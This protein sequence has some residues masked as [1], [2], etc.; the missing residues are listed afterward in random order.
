MKKGPERK[1]A[2]GSD[3]QLVTVGLPRDVHRMLRL[4][5]VDR[6]VTM[7]ELI[8]NAIDAWLP[9]HTEGKSTLKRGKV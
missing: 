8:R 2:G 5:S 7:A 4:L 3:V 6:R 9:S 1:G